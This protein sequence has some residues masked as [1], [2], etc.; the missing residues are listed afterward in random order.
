MRSAHFFSTAS[1]DLGSASG[2][3]VRR[4]TGSGSRINTGSIRLRIS[5]ATC[6][7]IQTTFAKGCGNTCQSHSPLRRNSH[8]P[9]PHSFPPCSDDRSI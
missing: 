5:A 9:G 2:S 8:T 4:V 3:S 1:H 6:S 7:S